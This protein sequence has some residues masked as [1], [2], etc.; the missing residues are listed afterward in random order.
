MNNL[1]TFKVSTL[2]RVVIVAALLGGAFAPTAFAAST[3][4]T[5]SGTV[6]TPITITQATNLNFGE[7]AASPSVAGTMTV[8]TGGAASSTEAVVTNNASVTAASFNVAGSANASFSISITDND[9]THATT[10]TAI[11]ALATKHDI[12]A[13]TQDSP[14]SAALDSTGARK[15]YVGGTLS[16]GAAQLAGNYSGTITATVE[17][18]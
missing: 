16:V 17:Y 11:M 6:V 1:K 18:N 14:A 7:F 8:T 13:V 3:T 2:G 15:V 12:D 5:S 9:L 4:A 10:T